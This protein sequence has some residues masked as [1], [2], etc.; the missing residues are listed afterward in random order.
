MAEVVKDFVF[1]AIAL[2][3]VAGSIGAVCVLACKP[4][5]APLTAD[6]V[7]VELEDSGCLA[8]GSSDAVAAELATGKDP[9]LACMFEGGTI[10]ACNAPC[11]R[12]GWVRRP[13]TDP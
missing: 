6:Q 3:I 8:P 9:W 11:E 13:T 7:A 1:G 5:A 10:Q 12:A 4:A 2:L